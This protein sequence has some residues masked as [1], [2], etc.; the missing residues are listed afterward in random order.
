VPAVAGVII[1]GRNVLLTLRAGPPYARTWDFPGGFLEADET[2]EH[3]MR[4]E[5]REELGI[6]TKRVTLLGFLPD[7]YGPD[8]LPILTIVFRVAPARG[9]M[10]ARDDVAEARWFPRARLPYRQVG[11]PSMRQALRLWVDTTDR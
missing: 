2:P 7:R 1:R 11:F 10:R 8:G 3:A 5:L 9:R 4:R 6:G